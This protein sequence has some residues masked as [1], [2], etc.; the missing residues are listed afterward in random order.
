MNT[1][2]LI[3][4][5]QIPSIR[6]ANTEV[7]SSPLAVIVRQNALERALTL[8]NLEHVKV[9]ITFMDFYQT[10]FE[11]ETTVWGLTEESICLKGHLYLPK[12]AI[13]ALD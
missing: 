8:G 5:E 2:V 12:K 6:F 9:R 3:Q 11:V 4:K 1:I 7:L 10:L 13:W